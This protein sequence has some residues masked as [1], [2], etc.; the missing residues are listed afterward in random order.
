MSLFISLSST[1]RIF[2]ILVSPGPGYSGSGCLAACWAVCYIRQGDRIVIRDSGR[3][4]DPVL[5][6]KN[7]KTVP[8]DRL[9]KIIGGAQVQAHGLIVND[10]DHNDRN[11]RQLGIAL[12][13][14]QNSPSIAVRHDTS[15]VISSGRTCLA[16]RIPSSPFAAATTWKSSF[17]RKRVIRSR[18]DGSSSIT[19]IVSKPVLV[20][21]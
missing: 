10:R 6:Y 13:P 9:D 15:R 8:V 14:I 18:T 21:V 1:S 12:E 11:L 20:S 5:F 17:V 16:R 2:C 7:G 3:P 4:G 19:R